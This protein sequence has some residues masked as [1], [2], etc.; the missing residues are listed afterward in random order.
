MVPHSWIKETLNITKVVKNIQN[1]LTNSMENWGTLLS[2]N[3]NELEKVDIRRG[4]FQ[5][6]S[7]SSLSIVMAMIPI[8]MILRQVS[9]GYCFSESREKVYH[10]LFMN[11]LKLYH[12]SLHTC[13]H[14]YLDTYIQTDIHTDRQIS[15]VYLHPKN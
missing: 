14:V 15:E 3:G 6:D 7:F 5:G 1:L 2:N 13:R 10:L 11:D 12:S 8:R 9:E 4:I